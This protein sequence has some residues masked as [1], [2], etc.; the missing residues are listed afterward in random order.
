MDHDSFYDSIEREY[1]RKERH[2]DIESRFEQLCADNGYTIIYM[3]EE[4]NKKCKVSIKLKTR[5]DCTHYHL[6]NDTIV[7]VSKIPEAILCVKSKILRL[8][9]K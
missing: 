1:D 9:K 5:G 2:K 3:I 8:T 6:H 7:D 4:Y